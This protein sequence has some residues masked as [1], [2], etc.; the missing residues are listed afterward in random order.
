MR[1]AAPDN[2]VLPGGALVHTEARGS[3]PW[4]DR[5]AVFRVV[6]ADAVLVRGTHDTSNQVTTRKQESDVV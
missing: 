6:A 2:A 4:N 3:V 1:V 5:P